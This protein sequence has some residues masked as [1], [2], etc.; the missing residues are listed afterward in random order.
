MRAFSSTYYALVLL[1]ALHG[2]QSSGGG[3]SSSNPI[4]IERLQELASDSTN[5]STSTGNTTTDTTGTS[6]DIST[7]TTTDTPTVDSVASTPLEVPTPSTATVYSPSVLTY[8]SNDAAIESLDFS[9]YYDGENDNLAACTNFGG[10]TR[11]CQGFVRGTG[12][13]GVYDLISGVE[14]VAA[15]PSSSI[16]SE[17]DTDTRTTQW[18]GMDGTTMLIAP[19]TIAGDTYSVNVQESDLITN[20][21]SLGLTVMDDSGIFAVIVVMDDAADETQTYGGYGYLNT[22]DVSTQADYSLSDY[23]ADT[24]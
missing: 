5:Q 6:T 22:S 23:M 10:Q 12:S 18:T 11:H 21:W 13:V 8:N 16:I 17:S 20:R 7:G 9:I 15:D 1:L 4:D 14:Y 2:C 24:N 19:P 3:S